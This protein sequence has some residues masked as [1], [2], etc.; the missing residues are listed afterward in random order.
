M[1]HFH[2]VVGHGQHHL[3]PVGCVR[4][5]HDQAA[6]LQHRDDPRHRRRLHLLVVGEFARGHRLMAVKCRE[7]GKLNVGEDQLG[8]AE[9][10]ALYP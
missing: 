6:L 10:E 4:C 3:T 7:R 5:P 2:A 8:L 9:S 1:D